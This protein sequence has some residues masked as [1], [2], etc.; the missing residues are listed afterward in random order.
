MLALSLKHVQE[1]EREES[2]ITI[3]DTEDKV[4]RLKRRHLPVQQKQG[5]YED[6]E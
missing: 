2:R 5:M 1:S 4:A 3:R 6:L